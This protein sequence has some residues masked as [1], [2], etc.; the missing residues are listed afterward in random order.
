MTNSIHDFKVKDVEG[1]DVDLADYKGKV[2][3]IVNTASECGF[4]PQYKGME[5]LRNEFKDQGFEVLA[6]PSND[7]QGQEPLEGIE[8]QNFCER[9]YETTFPI[10]EKVH[11]KGDDAH[12]LFKFLSNKKENGKVNSTPKWNFHKYLVD[13]EGKV[14]DYYFSIT[15]PESSKVKKAV[16]KLIDQA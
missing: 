11:V 10:M 12:P 9:N 6:F 16:K 8:I 15:K 5:E 2:L 7:F 14:I 1:K 3:L 4:T 13:K